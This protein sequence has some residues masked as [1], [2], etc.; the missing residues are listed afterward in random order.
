MPYTL[1]ETLE[2]NGPIAFPRQMLAKHSALFAERSALF[3]TPSANLPK[4]VVGSGPL[5]VF[6]PLCTPDFYECFFIRS[7]MSPRLWVDL[8][9]RHTGFIRWTPAPHAT[10]TITRFDTILIR[11]NHFIAG[12][13]AL[14]DALKIQ[15]N[16]R[17]DGQRLYYFGA[18]RDDSLPYMTA[19][20]EQKRASASHKIG[21]RVT[22]CATRNAKA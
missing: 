19:S 9:Q 10:V 2:E 7:Y 11:D 1:S 8:L 18:I 16:G 13:K 15:T 17:R 6:L 4:H 20:Y 3:F 5:D 14:L 21:M 12:T 22:S